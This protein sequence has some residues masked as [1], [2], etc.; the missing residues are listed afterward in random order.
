MNLFLKDYSFGN[1]MAVVAKSYDVYSDLMTKKQDTM[2][3]SNDHIV[4]EPDNLCYSISERIKGLDLLLDYDIVEINDSGLVYRAFANNEADTTIF[5]GAKCNSNCVM[6]PA[7]ENERSNGFSYSRDL[8]M[9][10]I[11]YLPDDLEYL[12]IT[13]GEPTM[14]VGLFL[15]VLDRVKEKYPSTQ[16]LLLTNGRSLSNEWLFKQVCEKRPNKL[17][18]AI[19]IHADTPELHDSITQIKNSFQQTILALTRLMNS[20]IDIEIRI[21]VT[22]KN[23]DRLLEIAKLIVVRF[24]NV[25]CINFIGLEPRGNCAMNFD[26]V[27]ID[28]NTS[29]EKSKNAIDYLISHG[30]DVG[31]YNY[32]LCA[33]DRDYWSIASKSISSYKNVYHPD[34]DKCNV[35]KICGGFFTATMSIAKPKVYPIR[36]KAESNE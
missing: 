34:C 32:P 18:I 29:F 26:D 2:Y 12:V 5:L 6:C 25:F 1:R 21:V 35:Q 8:L 30:Y 31:L 15:E 36:R 19:P 20:G 13:G 23:C 24:P 11:S 4:F 9:K 33:I 27:Y 14:Q 7:S 28:H 3:I 10:Y 17:R 16:V 22:K